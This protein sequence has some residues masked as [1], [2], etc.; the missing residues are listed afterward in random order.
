MFHDFLL[1]LCYY[2]CY[3][4]YVLIIFNNLLHMFVN[5]QHPYQIPALL[6]AE[7]AFPINIP[8]HSSTHLI[9]YLFF[10]VFSRHMV[11]LA[12]SHW[13][14]LNKVLTANSLDLIEFT[15]VTETVDLQ[16]MLFY[17]YQMVRE[18]VTKTK[19]RVWLLEVQLILQQTP[20]LINKQDTLSVVTA[21]MFHQLFLILMRVNIEKK[22]A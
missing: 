14:V 7:T 9:N 21:A 5:K 17:V 15:A 20:K 2:I 13:S 18:V 12:F 4:F 8:D 11:L 1:V 22:T 3:G 10:V 16:R 6:F 19:L